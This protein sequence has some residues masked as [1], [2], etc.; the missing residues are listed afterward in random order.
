[1]SHAGKKKRI[2]TRSQVAVRSDGRIGAASPRAS[3]GAAAG[4]LFSSRPVIQL[5]L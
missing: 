2:A 1:M 5:W 3:G 4:Q